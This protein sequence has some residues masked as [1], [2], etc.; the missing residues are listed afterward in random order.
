MNKLS[1]L[2]FSVLCIFIISCNSDYTP[3]PRGYFK[4]DFPERAY[5]V[6]DRVEYPYSFEYPVYANITK[7]STLFEDN[8]DNQYWINVD[9]PRFHGRVYLSYKTIGGNSIYKVKSANGYK[10]SAVKNTF[11]GLRDEAFRMTFKHSLKASGIVDSPFVS[12]QGISGVYFTVDG[13]AATSK[14]FFLTDSSKHFLRGALYFDTA[15]NSDSLSIVNDFIEED[16]RYLI[17]TL[18][19]K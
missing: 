3:R 6:F 10:D 9:F 14:Q 5:Q 17:N 18:K 16:M 4:I 12:K 8:L 2:F 11:E 15:P 19:W 13:N 7:D 1:Q